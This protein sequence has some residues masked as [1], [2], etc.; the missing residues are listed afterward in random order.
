MNGP[1][2]F[3]LS[4]LTITRGS[5]FASGSPPRYKRVDGEIVK[6]IDVPLRT[7]C[8]DHDEFSFSSILAITSPRIIYLAMFII[9]MLTSDR[10]LRYTRRKKKESK[11]NYGAVRR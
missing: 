2:R 5:T 1:C 11:E 10:S 3:E 4:A 6:T 8:C 9:H 7:S